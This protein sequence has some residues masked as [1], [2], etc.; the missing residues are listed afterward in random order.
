MDHTSQTGFCRVRWSSALFNQRLVASSAVL[1]IDEPST[2]QDRFDDPVA[3]LAEVKVAVA[4]SCYR[5]EVPHTV[6]INGVHEEAPVVL[7]DRLA[8]HDAFMGP[9][10]CSVLRST[11]TPREALG[12]RA[13]TLIYLGH[14]RL[15]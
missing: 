13:Q 6:S 1:D 14:L 7:G 9:N 8:A 3:A 10:L 11:R 5:V 2:I 15:K 4:T 12:D